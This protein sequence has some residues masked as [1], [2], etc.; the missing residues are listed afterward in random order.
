MA[1]ERKLFRFVR[2]ND[3][4][5][6][7]ELRDKYRKVMGDYYKDIYYQKADEA[8]FSY[9]STYDS[10]DMENK[11]HFYSIKT[12]ADYIRNKQDE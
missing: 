6:F 11:E 5:G 9:K 8:N 12:I 2:R 3:K 7:Y 4:Y 10:A 1:D